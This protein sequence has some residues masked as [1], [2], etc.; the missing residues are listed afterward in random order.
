MYRNGFIVLR[1]AIPP[2]MIHQAVRVIN[3]DLGEHGMAPDELPTLRA[4]SYC[5]RI[6]K[7]ADLTNLM[8][9]TPVFPL[10]ESLLGQPGCLDR[11]AQVQVALRFPRLTD[12]PQP[13]GGH[14]DGTYSPTNG[15]K[16]NTFATFTALAVVLLCD[17]P[18]PNL[19]NFT[20]WPG[21]HWKFQ[22][23][24]RTHGAEAI[25]QGT[26]R[27]DVGAPLQ[28]T[29]RAG[30]LV[31]AHYLLMHAVGPHFGSHIRYAA[32]SRLVKQGHRERQREV[33]T[34]VFGEWDGLRQ[35][36]AAAPAAVAQ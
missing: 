11:V 14:L 9:A 26:P 21:S 20:V 2:V 30:D 31:I 8:N 33:F 16:P 12:D 4:Q 28:I 27:L 6:R 18:E 25:F 5:P 34:D 32:I 15:V 10:A 29:G 19:G 7:H 13:L 35:F 36:T 1:G 24:F 23:Y 17:L 3:H 22:D